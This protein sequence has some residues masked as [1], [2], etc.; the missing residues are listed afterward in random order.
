MIERPQGRSWA[1]RKLGRALRRSVSC[2][3]IA[4]NELDSPEPQVDV[5]APN[6]IP[7]R[8]ALFPEIASTAFGAPD[9]QSWC[10]DLNPQGQRTGAVQRGWSQ[11]LQKLLC[12]THMY[13]RSA[14]LHS[15]ERVDQHRVHE[16]LRR[17]AICCTRS[18]LFATHARHTQPLYAIASKVM[19]AR[20]PRTR[21]ATPPPGIPARIAVGS[22]RHLQHH[23]AQL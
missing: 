6:G 13:V 18:R 23:P 2:V 3:P 5:S 7:S 8:P 10:V 14:V 21:P 17:Y 22:C 1:S 15:R 12:P 19:H 20:W 11:R 9:V 4:Q 16:H